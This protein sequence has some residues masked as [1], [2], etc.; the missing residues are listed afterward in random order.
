[1]LAEGPPMIEVRPTVL[2]FSE[3]MKML[4]ALPF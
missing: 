2:N 4:E 1:M 3:S